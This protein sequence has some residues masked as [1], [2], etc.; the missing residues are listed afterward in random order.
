MYIHIST[1]IYYAW[2]S[3]IAAFVGSQAFGVMK[4]VLCLQLKVITFTLAVVVVQATFNFFLIIHIC[5]LFSLL[6]LLMTA[7]RLKQHSCA[8]LT[9]LNC[10]KS[11]AGAS[12]KELLHINTA[13]YGVFL[14]LEII[15]AFVA[16]YFVIFFLFF[17]YFSIFFNF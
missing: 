14:L 11:A 3:H 6:L 16:C 7:F 12:S 17:I 10:P 8:L 1:C 15:C 13:I 2:L 4:D 9:R 5:A